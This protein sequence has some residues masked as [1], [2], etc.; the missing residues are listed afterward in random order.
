MRIIVD[1]FG[2]DNA[3]LEMIKGAAMAVDTL[4]VD[5]TLVG[6]EET[7]RAVAAEH[8]ISL[9][10]MDIIDAPDVMEME[11]EPRTILKAK[12]NS[13]MAEGLRRV[14]AGE[15][16]A[17]VSA[18]STGALIM[19][20]TFIVKRIKG[21]SRP[22]LSPLIPSDN[23]PFLLIDCGANADCRPEMLVQFAQMGHIYMTR[24]L[25]R[26]EPKIGLLNIGTE[27]CK[28]TAL[29]QETYQLLKQ[30]DLPFIGNVEAREVPAG[31]ADIVV[32]DGFTGNI[33]LKCIEGT[34]STLMRNI[35]GIFKS[36]FITM[37]AALMV[38]PQIGAFKKKMDVSEHGGAPI[39]GVSKP[40]IKAHGNSDAKAFCSAIR[41]AA[42]FAQSG[43]IEAITEAVTPT[44]EE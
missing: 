38:K 43:V 10:K 39:I 13:S 19:G 42:N 11:D 22:A 3:P 14:A 36:N 32:A 12:K 16:D 21:V 4:D 26:K 20:A 30:S 1:A 27:E 37:L 24:V 23:E 2:G 8:V 28:G 31:A 41:Q 25:G 9:E 34:T 40:V 15:G 18:G 6:K 29:Q 17:F 33:L 5:V 44:N 7:I 35:K